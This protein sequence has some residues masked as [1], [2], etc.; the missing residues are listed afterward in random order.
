MCST[1]PTA[2]PKSDFDKY[3]LLFCNISVYQMNT[4]TN[5]NMPSVNSKCYASVGHRTQAQC[6]L[7]LCHLLGSCKKFL[8]S[9]VTSFHIMQQCEER[10]GYDGENLLHFT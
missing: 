8:G 6:F 2:L 7:H 9:R 1:D 5:S 3:L 4:V 10:C